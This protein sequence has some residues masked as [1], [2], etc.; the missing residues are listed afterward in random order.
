MNKENIKPDLYQKAFDEKSLFEVNIPSE[1]K[2]YPTDNPL[3]EGKLNIMEMTGKHEN[4]LLSQKYVRQGTQYDELLRQL[5]VE[6]Y[7]GFEPE[8]LILEDKLYLILAVRIYNFG[9]EIKI[10]SLFAGI[11]GNLF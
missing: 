2:L 1:G 5:V 7:K 3:S 8:D 10:K 6:K 11:L 9:S 4:I